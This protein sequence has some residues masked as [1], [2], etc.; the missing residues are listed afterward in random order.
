MNEM[1]YDE[2]TIEYIKVKH[3]TPLKSCHRDGKHQ[4]PP[5]RSKM[6]YIKGFGE[7]I[8]QLLLYVNVSHLYISLLYMVSQEVVSH[9]YVLRSLIKK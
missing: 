6:S 9:F 7:N 5:Q 1:Q 2:D 4:V 8:R 3:K